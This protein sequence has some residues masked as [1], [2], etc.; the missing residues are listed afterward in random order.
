MSD[1]KKVSDMKASTNTP[2]ISE[3]FTNKVLDSPQA[4]K[5]PSSQLSLIDDDQHSK[6]PNTNCDGNENNLTSQFTQLLDPLL[7]QF[8]SLR[9]TVNS[10]ASSLENAIQ[11]QRIEVSEELHKIDCSLNRHKEDITQ[12]L[13]GEILS[14]RDNIQH[15]VEEN[16]NLKRENTI[17]KERLT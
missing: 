17:L 10:K 14:N 4:T 16:K 6:K 11:Q 12:Q 13:H 7:T 2:K 5:R 15:I 3:I 1:T 8:K 9:E